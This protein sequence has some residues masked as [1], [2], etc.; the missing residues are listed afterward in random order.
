[1]QQ[2]YERTV[3]VGVDGSPGALVAARYALGAAARRGLD[4]LLVYGYPLPL[5]D[6]PVMGD[7]FESLQEAG[8][9]VLDDAVVAL[10]IPPT[11]RVSTQVAEGMPAVTMQRLS[12]SARLMV[13]GQHSTAWYDRLGQGTVASPLAHRSGC[14]VVVVPPAWRERRQE[15]RPVVVAL[16]GEVTGRAALE[17]AFDEAELLG[18]TVVAL[19]AVAGGTPSET[20]AT[21]RNVDALLAGVRADHPSTTARVT[22]VRGDPKQLILSAA[23]SAAVLVCGP[24]HS[25]GFAVW[26]RSMARRVLTSVECPMVIV[27]SRLRV[28]TP[29]RPDV[30][31]AS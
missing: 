14:P 5:I 11:V 12:Q 28:S 26:T 3:V 21:E 25:E 9:S 7:F 1:M 15:R 2:S 10:E 30:L 8:R 27:P 4:V 23:Q 24:P 18:S 16:D 17:F 22:T 31:V 20:E 6:A 19:H 13:V 29:T